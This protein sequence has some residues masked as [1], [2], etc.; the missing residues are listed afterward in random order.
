MD[1]YLQKISSRI[2]GKGHFN[3][4]LAMRHKMR[5]K[6]RMNKLVDKIIQEKEEEDRMKNRK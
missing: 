4:E 3:K 5:E 1:D 2:L 6:R